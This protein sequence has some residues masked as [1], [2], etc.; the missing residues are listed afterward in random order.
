MKHGEGCNFA[1]IMTVNKVAG[2][3]H[4]AMGESTVKDEGHIHHFLPE[5]VPNFNASHIIHEL[6]FGAKYPNMED[7]PLV[8]V[9]KINSEE[10]GGT[11]QYFYFLKV[12]PTNYINDIESYTIRTNRYSYTEKFRPLIV[13]VEDHHHDLGHGE[14]ADVHTDK[15]SR[16][17]HQ[18]FSSILPGVF[19]IYE[20]YPFAVEVSTTRIP[21]SHFLIR[22]MAVVGGVLTLSS[23]VDS[24]VHVKNT[25]RAS[26]ANLFQV[27]SKE[28]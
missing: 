22:A 2:N 14:H 5:D 13:K 3:F 21:F 10:K 4:I 9:Q 8:G 16:S 12:V 25:K 28:K 20:L 19:F 7:G 24:I 17:K 15:M 1:G 18:F 23:W 27:T 26:N 6:S 11:G